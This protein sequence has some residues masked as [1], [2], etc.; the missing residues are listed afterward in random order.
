MLCIMQ[1]RESGSGHGLG[2]NQL[3]SSP[4]AEERAKIV[5]I[6]EVHQEDQGPLKEVDLKERCWGLRTAHLNPE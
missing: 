6:L 1:E 4:R 2:F 5:K 3:P